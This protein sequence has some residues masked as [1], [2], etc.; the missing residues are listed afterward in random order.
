MMV[1]LENGAVV[2]P[3]FAGNLWPTSL[4]GGSTDLDPLPEAIKWD[5]HKGIESQDPLVANYSMDALVA[6]EGTEFS[7]ALA[8]L[9]RSSNTAIREHALKIIYDQKSQE[10]LL[11]NNKR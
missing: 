4:L 9:T 11:R 5:F 7:P 10:A 1:Y 3:M 2:H 8:K 6:L